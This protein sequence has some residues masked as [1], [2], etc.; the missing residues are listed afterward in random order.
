MSPLLRSGFCLLTLGANLLYGSAHADA[1]TPDEAA[2][3]QHALLAEVG[4]E[5]FTAPDF[6]LGNVRHMVMFRFRQSATPEQRRQ[7]TEHF[8]ALAKES[9]RP[10]HSSV[11]VSIETG[12]QNSGESSD[13]GLERAYLVTFRSEGDRNFYVGQPVVTD[14]H[15]FD[16]AHEAFKAFA[17]PYLAKVVVFDFTTD[18]KTTP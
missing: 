8:M 5:R 13:L 4:A 7:V 1:Q 11:V 14:S 3:S 12:A 10:D 9:R 16:A 18:A 17:K 6:H 15:Y 2:R